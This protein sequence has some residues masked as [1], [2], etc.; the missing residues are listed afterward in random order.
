MLIALERGVRALARCA[1]PLALDEPL[2]P[3]P[4]MRRG[5]R[6]EVAV[7]TSGETVTASNGEV[8]RLTLE[9]A[10]WTAVEVEPRGKLERM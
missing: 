3:V 8:Y 4:L 7:G 1:W 2:K 6:W 9:G 10:N 5:C